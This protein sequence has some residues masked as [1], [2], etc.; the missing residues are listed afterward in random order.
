MPKEIQ[1]AILDNGIIQAFQEELENNIYINDK[2]I[3][4]K[5]NSYKSES[6]SHG[7]TCFFILKHYAKDSRI[8]SVKILNND[9][10]GGIEKLTPALEWCC[11]HNIKIVNLSLGSIHF[12][13]AD[14]IQKVINHYANRGLII[15][16]ASSN[17]GYTS[18]PAYF[19]NVIGVAN[20]EDS[21]LKDN[22]VNVNDI[23]TGV[24]FLAVSEHSVSIVNEIITVPRSNSYAAPF[25]SSLIYSILSSKNDL[26]IFKIKRKLINEVKKQ[27]SEESFFYYEPNWIENAY[28]V[29]EKLNSKA[30]TYFNLFEYCNYESIKEKI[31]TLIIFNEKDLDF[32]LK[33]NKHIIYLGVKFNLEKYIGEKYI[34]HMSLKERKI[35]KESLKDGDIDIPIIAI[36]F[37][38]G[39]DELWILQQLKKL[40]ADE[41][42]NAYVSSTKSESVLYNLEYI[43]KKYLV[44]SKD[45][46]RIKSFL[47]EETYYKRSDIII[48]GNLD[49]VEN[50]DEF[51][52][53]IGAQFVIDII[54]C[55]GY[56]VVFND[57]KGKKIIK[58]YNDISINEIRFMY[59]QIINTFKGE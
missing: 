23:H 25:V 50:L 29:G 44:N 51:Q 4:Q 6:F 8:S 58:E 10:M 37:H 21:E 34:W 14:I 42:Y 26:T 2:N 1:V 32:Y 45:N 55:N 30:R 12:K 22:V 53:V 49:N 31:D 39:M 43:P 35:D 41:S 33:E 15:I 19:S 59:I 17:S 57:N 48:L 20:I 52:H 28:I 18:Y 13:D 27:G 46:K 40:F 16:S 38:A 5:Q 56:K 3:I 47:Y 54:E 36:K 7:T 24:D 11:N 9:G